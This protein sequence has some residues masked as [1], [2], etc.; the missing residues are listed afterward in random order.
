MN[1]KIVSL[2]IETGAIVKQVE[3]LLNSSKYC[4]ASAAQTVGYVGHFPQVPNAADATTGHASSLYSD[5]ALP[6]SASQRNPS[7]QSVPFSTLV[8]K[9]MTVINKRKLNVVVSG[10]SE[11]STDGED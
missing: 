2:E 6:G 1:T 4:S 5:M 10:L 3:S 11:N 7:R 9:T 8:E